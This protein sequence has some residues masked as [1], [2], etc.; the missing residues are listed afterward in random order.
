MAF[1]LNKPVVVFVQE[2]TDV[3][4]FIPNITQYITLDGTKNDFY[5]KKELIFSLLNNAYLKVKELKNDKSLREVGNMLVY[6]LAIYGGY[7][8]IE[9][10]FKK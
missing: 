10:I 6:G 1:A 7:K 8:L 5:R 2:G 9:A 3:G 4:N